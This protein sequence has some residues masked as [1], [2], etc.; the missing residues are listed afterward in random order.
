MAAIVWS[1]ITTRPGAP[2]AL[3]TVDVGVQTVWLTMANTFLDVSLFDGEGGMTTKNARCLYVL[4]MYAMEV[5]AGIMA[6]VGATGPVSKEV[7]SKLTVEYGS[8][9]RLAGGVN[10]D[11]LS[12]TMYGRALLTLAWPRTRAVCP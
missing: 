11:P 6:T 3:A 8:L 1:D 10:N 4:H 9:D 2:V 5:I 7:A 12:M